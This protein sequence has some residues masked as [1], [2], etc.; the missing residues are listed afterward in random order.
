MSLHLRRQKVKLRKEPFP[1]GDHTV[2]CL[3]YLLG[4]V[5]ET[6]DMF[7]DGEQME[8][9][10]TRGEPRSDLRLS[11]R[12]PIRDL[13]QGALKHATPLEATLV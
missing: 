13:S 7:P 8:T 1:G 10:E 11:G 6:W 9:T 12:E 3:T 2:L 5:P 4:M